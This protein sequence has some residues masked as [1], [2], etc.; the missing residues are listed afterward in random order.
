M[1]SVALII[2]EPFGFIMLWIKA[3]FFIHH[4]PIIEV[5]FVPLLLHGPNELG[6]GLFVDL[7]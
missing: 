5:P 3:F 7:R 1:F 4:Q 2:K 6:D